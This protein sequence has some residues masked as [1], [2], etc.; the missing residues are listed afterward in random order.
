[1]EVPDADMPSKRKRP[2][3]TIHL[4][5]GGTYRESA[6]SA[7]FPTLSALEI[8]AAVN[9]R[10]TSEATV[11][12]ARRVGEIMGRR[13]GTGPDDDPFLRVER[14]LSKREGHRE[15]RIE[16]LREGR[17]QGHREGRIEGHRE[18][19]IEGHREGRIEG[20]REGRRDERIAMLEDLLG[21]R[22][23]DI[24]PTLRADADRIAALPLATI[25]HAAFESADI[26]DFMNRLQ[27]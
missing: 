14:Q 15:G 2:G 1:M 26:D 25:I 4:L 22:G 21:M 13:A 12:V 17:V 18:G 27:P 11:E 5:D 10:S 23:I 19:R 7:A 3:L 20:H 8:H 6:E 16:G 9:E 24:T